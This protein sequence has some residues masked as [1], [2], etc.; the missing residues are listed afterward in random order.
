M[1]VCQPTGHLLTHPV[2]TV[3]SFC[4]FMMKCTDYGILISS[5]LTMQNS[6]IIFRM[7]LGASQFCASLLSLFPPLSFPVSWGSWGPSG[8]LWWYPETSC[9]ACGWVL[10]SGGMLLE[11]EHG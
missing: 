2:T 6:D 9:C 8:P 1:S 11:D 7:D 3:V 5:L 10:R 4:A